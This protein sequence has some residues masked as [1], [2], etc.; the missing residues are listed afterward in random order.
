M[1]DSWYD[2]VKL[3][4]G[5]NARLCVSIADSFIVCIKTEDIYAEIVRD[6]EARFDTINCKLHKKKLLI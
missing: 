2:Y 6:V 5:E 3:K 1:H 4:Y